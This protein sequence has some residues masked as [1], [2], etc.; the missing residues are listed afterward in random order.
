MSDFY[1]KLRHETIG[2]L[3]FAEPLTTAQ[4]VKVEL[5]T[6]LR[7]A[8]DSLTAAQLRGE[9]IDAAKLLAASTALERM[10]PLTV[11]QEAEDESA[12]DALARII[13]GY[14]DAADNERADRIAFLEAELAERDKMIAMLSPPAAETPPPPKPLKPA[15]E[16]VPL[17]SKA[18]SAHAAWERDYYGGGA[19]RPLPPPG[20]AGSPRDW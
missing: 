19:D 3:G 14:A 4:S 2:L 1:K 11:E 9:T 5:V 10:L 16:V 12:R 15:A 13:D 17:R 8:L 6:S 20:S 7:L 18:E